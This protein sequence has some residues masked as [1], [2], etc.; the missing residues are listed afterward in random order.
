MLGALLRAA[1]QA[2]RSFV[3]DE[4]GTLRLI[5]EPYLELL[6]SFRTWLTMNYFLAA[7]KF[8]V[9]LFGDSYWGL[10]A[11]PLVAGVATIPLA[12]LLARRFLGP[13][14]ALA[15]GVLLAIHPELVEYSVQ[16][17][18]YSLFICLTLVSLLAFERWLDGPSWRRGALFA[19]ATG[20][21]LLSH[22]NGA[23]PTAGV[24]ALILIRAWTRRRAGEALFATLRGSASILLPS[25][26]TLAAIF[27]AY[28]PILPEMQQVGWIFRST[29]PTSLAYLADSWAILFGSGFWSWP[30][31]FLF[32]LGA[33]NALRRELPDRRLLLVVIAGPTLMSLQGMAIYP[34]AM[35]RY[36]IYSL[37]LLILF[38][39]AG[40][41]EL[42]RFP[43]DGTGKGQHLP[44]R[45]LHRV[46]ALGCLVLAA[47]WSPRL[48]EA[49]EQKSNYPWR[50]LKAT[51]ADLPGPVRVVGLNFID[52]LHMDPRPEGHPLTVKRLGQ[53]R[54]KSGASPAPTTVL[55]G[56]AIDFSCAGAAR[57]GRIGY[58][59]L[60]EAPSERAVTQQAYDCLLGT[61]QDEWPVAA[62]YFD[63][64]ESL[65]RLHRRLGMDG[66]VQRYVELREA[67]R[68][69]QQ[70]Q[71]ER[72][73]RI[74]KHQ[75]TGV[76]KRWIRIDETKRR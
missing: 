76:S 35:T 13:A 37:P 29:P 44:P 11:L 34:W 54:P 71:I 51:L 1:Y 36:L 45:R 24:L 46:L 16:I 31:L 47:S 70:A 3:G 62:E 32:T 27:V 50:D 2:G 58:V 64:Y 4:I 6:S 7:E 66:D 10:V 17:R 56:R 9:D 61:V 42:A 40:M 57:A 75:A 25:A 43:T 18:S 74:L 21:L 55:V 59:V 49:F 52:A 72:P 33:W 23:Y 38:V 63:V 30:T 73:P 8:I 15:C 41:G 39:V 5:E 53:L 28:L 12:A 69:L 22:P 20:A 19:T 48:L 67:S 14:P 68:M 26:V 60:E 65:F